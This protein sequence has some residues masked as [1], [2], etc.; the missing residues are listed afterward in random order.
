MRRKSIP[1][2]L[3]CAAMLMTLLGAC[4]GNPASDTASTTAAAAGETTAA[5]TAAA[6]T[7]AAKPVTLTFSLWDKNQ[8]PAMQA[9]ADGFTK[10]NPNV[11]INVECSNWNDYWTKLDAAAQ[12]GTL[13][14]IFWM[15]IAQ[16]SKYVKGNMLQ[17]LD[18]ILKADNYDLSQ[19]PA[20]LVKGGGMEGKQYGIPKDFDT[21]GLWYNKTLF[22][23]K[24]VPYPTD[25]WTWDDMIAAGQK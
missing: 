9:M 19:F 6:A 20:A 17:P 12:T 21:I 5:Q 10:L 25:T 13:P 24:Q 18:D 23:A 11:K 1:V 14:D 3:L 15:H 16:L 8:Q 2:L 22:D 4:G 7:E